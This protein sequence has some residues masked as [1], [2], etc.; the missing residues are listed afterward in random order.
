MNKSNEEIFSLKEAAEFLKLSLSSMYKKTSLK[1][2]PHYV[3]GGKKIYFKKSEL[4]NWALSHK[5]GSISESESDIAHY[6]S[7]NSNNQIS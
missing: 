4:E 1:Q 6:L 5:V 7:R 2:I 3:P